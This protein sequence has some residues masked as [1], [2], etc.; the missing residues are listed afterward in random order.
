MKVAV[1]H[2]RDRAGVLNVFG[3]QNRERY[4]PRTVERVASAL[5]KG[6]HTVRVVDGNM[7]VIEQLRDFMPR[8][9][10]GERPGMVFNMAYGIQGVSRYTHLPAML[11]MLGVP[12]VGSNPMAHGLA[13]DKVIAKIVFKN[14]GLP[15]PAFWNFASSDDQFADLRFPVIV[16]PKMEA[17]SYG[18]RVVD[19]ESDLRDAVAELIKEFQQHV[20]VEE[21]IVGR[22]FAI[23]L[24]GNVDPEVLPIVEI[25]LEDPKDIQTAGDKLKKPLGKICP[26]ELSPDKTEEL[27][28][29]VLRAFRSLEL[30]D[31]ARVDIRM[32]EAGKPYILEI[33]SMASLGLTGTYVHAAQTAGY[34]YDSLINRIL[35]VAAVRYFGKGYLSDSSAERKTKKPEKLSVR[36]RS[37][38]RS[39]G[40]TIEE[41]LAKMVELRT[42]V[43]DV[44]NVN[45][46]GE[47]LTA[48]MK[49]LGFSAKIYPQVQT[50]SVIYFS[51]HDDEDDVLL[52]GHLDTPASERAFVPYREDGNRLYG[53]GIAESK[54]G[55]AVALAA[56]RALRYSRALRRI[57]CGF[58]LTSDDTL[59]GVCGREFVRQHSSRARHVIGLKPAG[60][61]GELV[62]S[63][64][65]RSTYKLEAQYGKRKATATSAHV[66]GHL[67]RRLRALQKLSDPEGGVQVS[68]RRIHVDAPFGRLPDRA[69]ATVTVRFN[70]LEDG[71]RIHDEIKAVGKQRSTRGVRF[72]VAGGMRRPPMVKS[73]GSEEFLQEIARIGQR[74]HI[75]LAEAHRWHSSDICFAAE[76]VPKIDGMGPIGFGERTANE[77]V[78]RSSL[79]DHAAL[80]ALV[81]RSC[82]K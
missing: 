34:T 29:L 36:V 50:G 40:D 68:V 66:I 7:H 58:L 62:V 8:V 43:D 28:S 65:G 16:K 69:E 23:G 32:D 81:I 14:A 47:W 35:D 25:A 77:H 22:E 56:L 63:R 6:G 10:E 79:V 3:P 12:Y 5:E 60:G 31:F 67:F 44:E 76:D 17:V 24:L 27:R 71:E 72:R 38:L 15:T 74:I 82:R 73:Q 53:T 48:Q 51:N 42:P 59:S 26:P 54:G 46:F 4:N 75:P 20:L 49:Y 64:A 61:G 19:N 11:E 18:I 70:R 30:Y 1:V 57:R 52:L 55:I 80:L 13:L 41:L 39:Q 33:N 45:A 78:L 21:F 37:Y 2:N 9:I